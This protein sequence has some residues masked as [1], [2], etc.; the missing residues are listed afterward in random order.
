MDQ[1]DGVKGDLVPLVGGV[2]DCVPHKVML[3]LCKETWYHE[4]EGVMN[5]DMPAK[6][7]MAILYS[8]YETPLQKKA[9][10]LLTE[11]LME[12]TYEMPVC[13]PVG[14]DAHAFRTVR[15]GTVDRDPDLA[16]LMGA[17]KENMHPEGFKL[18]VKDGQSYIL[19]GS[20]L[21]AVYGCVDYYNRYLIH[22]FYPH[23][24]DY[25]FFPFAGWHWDDFAYESKPMIRDR[26]VWTWGHVI[27]DYRGFIDHMVLMKMNTLIVW[28]DVAPLNLKD[29]VD[30][31]HDNGVK[32]F[33]GFAWMWETRCAEADILNA[34]KYIPGILEKY[35][36][37]YLPLG[38]D[39]IYFQSFTE[40]ETEDI[41]GVLIADAVTQFVNK[42]CAAFYEKYPDLTIQFGLHATSVKNRLEYIRKVD[43]RVHILWE[44][45]GA[46][47]FDYLPSYVEGYKE[48]CDF[49]QELAVLRGMDDRFGAVTK[50][51]TKLDWSEF[52]HIPGQVVMGEGSAHFHHNRIERKKPIWRYLLAYWLVNGDKAKHM[53]QK[54]CD[55]KGDQMTVTA[56][57]EDGMLEKQIMFPAA[58]YG[59]MLWDPNQ[60]LKELMADVAQRN[61][62]HFE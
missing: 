11:F 9:V 53:L 54:L 49:A 55:L 19:G 41:G 24:G 31:A 46:F 32:V 38:G 6:Q 17:D 35:E 20:D 40:L 10:A 60:D 37:E 62:V 4:R 34:D 23:D 52:E 12:F 7:K 27:Y 45:C 1:Y 13:L 51:L 18:L 8:A 47:P 36:K 61:Y 33:F 39:G 16:A 5:M 58:L 44:N 56:L 26:G 42:A 48:T 59:E 50:G 14:S 15:V 25:F 30:Y 3:L 57:I 29:V 28:N 43:K 22:R 2:G 21:G